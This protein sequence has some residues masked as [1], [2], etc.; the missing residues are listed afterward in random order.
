MQVGREEQGKGPTVPV[1][2]VVCP[3][4]LALEGQAVIVEMVVM[5]RVELA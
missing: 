5:V 2:V 1:Q 3:V 4:Q